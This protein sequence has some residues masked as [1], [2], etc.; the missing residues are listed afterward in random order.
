MKASTTRQPSPSAPHL[1]S[2]AEILRFALDQ[3]GHISCLL[4]L[5]T[6]LRLPR[7][8]TANLAM[9]AISEVV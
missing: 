4:Q 6:L 8:A 2:F 3:F 5:M 7:L 9:T 1:T